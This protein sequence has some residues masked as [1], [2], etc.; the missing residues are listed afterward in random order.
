MKPWWMSKWA[1]A[2]TAG[3]AAAT[4]LLLASEKLSG[5]WNP[6][7]GV[8]AFGLFGLIVSVVFNVFLFIR[9]SKPGQD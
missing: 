8:A 3:V 1:Y 7:W 9:A 5:H 2:G 4:L 6:P